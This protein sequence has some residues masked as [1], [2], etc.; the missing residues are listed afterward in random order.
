MY[1]NSCLHMF[2]PLILNEFLTNIKN[3]SKTSLSKYEDIGP[4]CRAPLFNLKYFVVFLS[5]MMQDS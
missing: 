3:I 5:L 4:P 2:K 1:K